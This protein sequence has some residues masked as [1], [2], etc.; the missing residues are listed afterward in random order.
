MTKVYVHADISDRYDGPAIFKKAVEKDIIDDLL[1]GAASGD[2]DRLE[3][4]EDELD[5]TFGF[6]IILGAIL[7]LDKK[8]ARAAKRLWDSGKGFNIL[9]EEVAIGV[10]YTKDEASAHYADVANGE[11]EWDEGSKSSF[12]VAGCC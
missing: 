12:C 4:L 7:H 8:E 11:D 10:G 2:E 1:S 6:S 5:A 3:G 9:E